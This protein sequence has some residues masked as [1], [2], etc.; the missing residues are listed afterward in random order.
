[1]KIYAKADDRQCYRIPHLGL[2]RDDDYAPHIDNLCGGDDVRFTICLDCGTVIGFKPIS[3]EEIKELF[4]E[5]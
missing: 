4:D 1:M 5:Q 3:D 2:E